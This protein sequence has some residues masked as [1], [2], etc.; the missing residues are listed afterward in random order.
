[1]TYEASWKSVTES[2]ICGASQKPS[3]K[4]LPKQ[5]HGNTSWKASWNFILSTV[6]NRHECDSFTYRLTNK[7]PTGCQMNVNE[8]VDGWLVEPRLHDTTCCQTG[9]QTGLTTGWTNSGCSFNTVV[10]SV[11]QPIWQPCSTDKFILNDVVQSSILS[12]IT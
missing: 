10:K 5:R 12:E 1:M 8:W 7:H 3:Q 2:S 9:C 11:V 4:A 6:Y